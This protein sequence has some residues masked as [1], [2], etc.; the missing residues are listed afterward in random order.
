VFVGYAEA[1]HGWNSSDWQLM[2]EVSHDGGETFD[3]P[4]PIARTSRVMMGLSSFPRACWIPTLGVDPDGRVF[5]AWAETSNGRVGVFCATSTDHGRSWSEPVAVNNDDTNGGDKVLQYLVT[6]PSDG[7]AYVLF[8]DRRNDPENALA[9]MTLARSTDSGR[10][11][12]NYALA[13]AP[14]DP[15][16]ASFG[17]YIGAAAQNGI[18]YGAWPEYATGEREPMVSPEHDLGD[19]VVMEEGQWPYGPAAIKVGIADFTS[20][21]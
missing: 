1:A 15:R 12:A 7:A 11:F 4:V 10:S 5:A 6:D 3:E 14:T 21:T 19:G 8:Y 16:L 17:D 9:T 2:V 13:G 18:V 20:A